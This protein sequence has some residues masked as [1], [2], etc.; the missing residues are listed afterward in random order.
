MRDCR[1]ALGAERA[2]P[3]ERS[4]RSP[5]LDFDGIVIGL[6]VGIEGGRRI[7]QAGDH[8][9]RDSLGNNDVRKL[10]NLRLAE[11]YADGGGRRV[12]P[13]LDRIPSSVKT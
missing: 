1:V 8:R 11:V 4:D 3:A 10:T 6:R 5:R 9:H 7:D 2:G 12:S 13:N